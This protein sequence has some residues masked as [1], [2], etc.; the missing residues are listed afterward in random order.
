M[1]KFEVSQKH[2]DPPKAEKQSK[3]SDYSLSKRLRNDD[4]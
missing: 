2:C 1:K 3:K 4:E